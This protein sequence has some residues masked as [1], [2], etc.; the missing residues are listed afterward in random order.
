MDCNFVIN[1]LGGAAILVCAVAWLARS[2]VSQYLNKDIALFKADIPAKSDKE[3]ESL[4]AA[5]KLEIDKA[6]FQFNT[7]HIKRAEV[8][9]RLYE[10]LFDLYGNTQGLL[11]EF[12]RRQIREDLDRKCEAHRRES[13]EL[14]SG[15]HSLT[16]EE[17]IKIDE[18][19]LSV[20]NLF[21]FYKA[22]KIY[23]PAEVCVEIDRFLTLAS[24]TA[25]SYQNVAIKDSTGELIVNPQVKEVWEGAYRTIPG[26]LNNIES[27]FRNLLGA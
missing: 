9:A 10:M 12:E 5:L 11:H 20:R 16:E 3:I 2:L 21:S 14:V 6:S 4:K 1:T 24:Y 27:R 19:A 22:H 26:V 23:F 15:I 25:T 8:M 7:L 18:V 13:W 17:K